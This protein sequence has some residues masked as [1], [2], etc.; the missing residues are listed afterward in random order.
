MILTKE[1][2]FQTEKAMDREDALAIIN[3]HAPE[4]INPASIY[5]GKARLCNDQVD[6]SFERF[7]I[8]VLERFAQT[9][10]GKPVLIGHEMKS[11]P[12]GRWFSATVE[13][14]E[15]GITHLV[16]DFYLATESE[17]ARDIKLGIAKEMSIGYKAAPRTCDIC[18]QAYDDAHKL[19][20]RAGAV[21]QGKICTVTYSGDP[22]AYE[23]LEGSFVGIA[24]QYGAMAGVKLYVPGEGLAFPAGEPEAPQ[25]RTGGDEMEKAQL[26]ERNKALE[27]ELATLKAGFGDAETFAAEGKQYRADLI[28]EIGRKLGVLEMPAELQL[29]LLAAA[30]V[31]TL[32]QFD[33]DLGEKVNAKLGGQSQSKM[34]GNGADVVPELRGEKAAAAAGPPPVM[35]QGL[36]TS[37][38]HNWDEEE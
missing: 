25:D 22:R 4:P 23:A 29:K 16:A 12:V 2:Q 21:Y 3:K 19:T 18:G 32:K 37:V 36:R 31:G 7:P 5:L 17:L 11:K 20:H 30:D 34:L 6:R 8:P 35:G 9:L 14:D 33:T 28:T 27:S 38:F 1:L 10:P 24:C 26:E 15:T 13:P